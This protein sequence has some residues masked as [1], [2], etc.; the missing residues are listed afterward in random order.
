LYFIL[1]K[2]VTQLSIAI[3]CQHEVMWFT[4]GSIFETDTR[5]YICWSV[6]I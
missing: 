4:T 5:K 6:A 1:N 3:F 2:E